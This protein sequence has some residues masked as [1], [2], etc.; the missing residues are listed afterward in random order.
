MLTRLLL[1]FLLVLSAGPALAEAEV[2]V[3]GVYQ[4]PRSMMTN[5]VS[6]TVPVMLDRP[7]AEVTLVLSSF[8]GVDWQ[9]STTPG[10]PDPDFAIS[11]VGKDDAG[12]TI[13]LNGH[14][15][16]DPR[17]VTLPL[18]WR[19]E[20][21]DFRKL[22]RQVP[23]VFKV[24]RMA[25]Y[26]GSYDAPE[27][28]FVVDRIVADERYAVD[29]LHPKLAQVRL[30]ER[31]RKLLP[32]KL[33]DAPQP[34]ALT[35]DGFAVTGPDGQSRTIPLPPEMPP[36]HWPVAA[37]RDDAGGILYGVTADGGG[38]IY[39]YDETG[40]AWRQLADMDK[41]NAGGLL[42][43]PKG[44]RLV[45]TLSRYADPFALAV[46]DLAGPDD[47][48][49]TLVAD[50]SDLPGL[51]DLYDPGNGPEAILVP[52]GIDGDTV[53]LVSTGTMLTRLRPP[54]VASPWRAYLAE[55]ST[56]RVMFVG[57]EGGISGE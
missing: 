47:A 53:L 51:A 42:L 15:V 39:A 25:S 10:T 19:P 5:K 46:H 24:N 49:L 40:Q 37:V 41:A 55:L 18:T 1:C 31:L 23:D 27:E 32:P 52:I 6:R 28:G 3:V 57:Y 56:G 9:V 36:I 12:S 13:R 38:S 44:H 33:D 50:L 8:E 14:P 29:Y 54:A 20:G 21:E 34:V 7:G 17:R 35:S 30:P 22:V 43:D 48:P 2:H 26:A 11:Q 4:G 16:P 45:V